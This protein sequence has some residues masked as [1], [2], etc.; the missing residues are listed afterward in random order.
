MERL[1][2]LLLQLRDTPRGYISRKTIKGKVYTY[3]QYFHKGKVLS[4]YV[5]AAEL[6]DTEA[7]LAQRKDI[8]REVRE[9][10]SG[11]I[12]MPPLTKREKNFTG[13]LMCGDKVAAKLY[14]GEASSIDENLAPLFFRKCTNAST[15]FANRV[16]DDR[17]EN[18]RE[19]LRAVKIKDKD[20]SVIPFYVNGRSLT[21]NYWFK[22]SGA[23]TKFSDLRFGKNLYS[24]VAYDGLKREYPMAPGRTPEITTPGETEKCWIFENGAW[25][26]HKKET[27]EQVF[28]DQLVERL[29]R[30]L[31]FFTIHYVKTEDGVKCRNFAEKFNFEPFFGVVDNKDDYLGIF[32][33]L[34]PYGKEALKDYIRLRYLDAITSNNDRT[35]NDMGLLRN[36]Q[37]GEV[38]RLAPNFDNNRCLEDLK[39]APVND[40]SVRNFI[41]FFKSNKLVKKFARK[42]KI[43]KLK[44]ELFKKLI[45]KIDPQKKG[46][47]KIYR[48]FIISRVEFIKKYISKPLPAMTI[49]EEALE[50]AAEEVAVEE[51]AVEETPVAEEVIEDTS[52]TEEVVEETVNDEQPVEEEVTEEAPIEEQ[53]EETP[54]EET[55]PV[56]E[57]PAEEE[58]KEDIIVEEGMEVVETKV[59]AEGET[60]VVEKDKEGNFFEI[61]FSKSFE[62][63]LIQASDE[64]KSYY[65]ILKNEALSYNK[66]K[67]I[68]TWSFDSINSGRNP[69][70]K[71]AVRGKTLCAYFPLNADDYAE[72]KYKLEKITSKKFALVPSLYRIKSDRRCEYVKEL[73]AVVAEA[74]GLEK[75]DQQNE[76]YVL[77]YED[78]NALLARGLVREVKVKIDR[79][80]EAA[81]VVEEPATEEP[82]PVEEQP[83][84]E[85]VVEEAPVEEA[86]VEEEPTPEVVEEPA[87]EETAVEEAAPSEEVPAEDNEEVDDFV[88]EEG[89]EVVETKVNA[90]GETI[91]VEKDKEGNLFEIRFSKSFEAKLIQASD[92]AK[93]FYE[94]L[95]N[96][97]LSYKKSK[98]T[99]TWSFDSINCGRN[100]VMKFA[101]RG[102]TLCVY[103]PLNADDYADS[104]YKLEKITSKKFAAVPSLYRIKSDRRFNYAKELIA[105]V[106]K[107]LG[108]EK[109]SE[110]HESYIQPY[111]DN[112]ALLERGLIREVKV[113]VGSKPV[114]A[115]PVAEAVAVAAAVNEEPAAEPAPVEETP[116][117]EAPVVEEVP[118]VEETPVEE[119]A[120][121]A[122]PVEDAPAEEMPVE[123]LV[124]EVIEEAP[125]EDVAEEHVAEEESVGDEVTEEPVEEEA[126]P[127]EEDVEDAPSEE[128]KVEEKPKKK[129]LFA[130]LF[131]KKDKKDKKGKAVEEEPAP[132]EAPVE[133]DVEPEEVPAEEPNEELASEGEPA[134][135][136][137]SIDETAPV[138]NTPVEE[139][140]AEEANE[141]LL[142]DE[143]PI[144]EEAPAEES[145]ADDTNEEVSAETPVEEP[146]PEEVPTEEPAVEETPVAEEQI[147]EPTPEEEAPVVEETVE[148][149]APV[150]EEA[151]VEEPVE[152]PVED[153]PVEEIPAEEANEELLT[154]EAPTEESVADEEPAKE[155]SDDS[156]PESNEVTPEEVVNE[157]PVEE[158]PAEEPVE[159]EASIEDA[160]Q[161]ETAD[162][163]VEEP[164]D[165]VVE[166]T[167][168]DESPVDESVSE[169]IPEDPAEEEQVEESPKKKGF[170]GRLFG[171]KDKKK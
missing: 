147:E 29:A 31:D 37:T 99:V 57:V 60:I 117:E 76:S 100:P 146:A 7:K 23:V 88:A 47:F 82:A 144:V 128:E 24:G 36:K 9:L 136:E 153:A 48:D 126:T 79:P 124:D 130:R 26:M 35:L 33:F 104:K 43:P 17:R 134:V 94:G 137:A 142:T 159:D 5:P 50:T 21:D 75:G 70:I 61:R 156:E 51:A 143:T 40:P 83:I 85:A 132:E 103:F 74:L 96:E 89:M 121:E 154:D 101:V 45:I 115:A 90:E 92:E 38:L 41:T 19:L 123:E 167:T 53:A 80:A 52:V 119:S 116:V 69:V 169:E 39:L 1:D 63:K 171:K 95:K 107:N 54:V 34:K 64:A 166:D 114:D 73:I 72:S 102:K 13:Y 3:R 78:N 55:A 22:P 152:E 165:E 2:E 6:A 12:E 129:G 106:N 71:F 155:T 163:S 139:I 161:E 58:E 133:E 46:E 62:A 170:F 111:E 125:A 105:E 86:V 28:N 127:V 30:E 148:E 68:V 109:V 15:Y 91:V 44:P 168:N 27:P 140:P 138:E 77:P 66:T 131:G 4:F 151:P 42:A 67:S 84:E 162:D 164:V 160:D 113:K 141:E 25:W 110:E 150:V 157:E 98:S 18:R 20:S 97:A 108:F 158:A 32:E 8:E 65:E 135:E 122:A 56:E 14:K 149:A 49:P 118:A 87:V 59:N 145:V 11:Y 16:I 112:K 10:S 93:A 81:P 120:E